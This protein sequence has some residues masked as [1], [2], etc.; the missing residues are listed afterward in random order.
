MEDDVGGKVATF[1]ARLAHEMRTERPAT[2]G[3]EVKGLPQVW[4]ASFSS[5]D[6]RVRTFLS[7]FF[8]GGGLVFGRSGYGV[9]IGHGG[10]KMEETVDKAE[11]EGRKERGRRG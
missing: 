4:V 10:W 11:E 5:G 2:R 9:W 8:V 6:R 7:F 1:G 3:G